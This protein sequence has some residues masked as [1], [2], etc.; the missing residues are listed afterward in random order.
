MA[1]KKGQAMRHRAPG[2][3][4]N[5]PALTRGKQKY[6]KGRKKSV[7]STGRP[8]SAAVEGKL[9]AAEQA[10]LTEIQYGFSLAYLGNG[11]NARQ[12]YLS[13]CPH[14]TQGSADVQGH[15][16]LR[17]D[18]VRSFLLPQLEE[19]WSGMLMEGTEALARVARDARA[20][21]TLLYDQ[22]GN[23]MKPRDWPVEVKGSVKSIQDGPYGLKVSLVDPLQARRIIL[24]QTGK[25]KGT[26]DSIDA[27]AA[28]IRGDMEKHGRTGD[29][30][31]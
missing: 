3:V 27:L 19:H 4:L 6:K 30:E 16:M 1:P 23:L 20:D 13:V 21:I 8:A 17:N 5:R 15:R 25:L 31:V 11:F 12:A 10:D 2:P 9:S 7:P 24:E 18:K 22:A 28:A 29:E 14:V 26:A